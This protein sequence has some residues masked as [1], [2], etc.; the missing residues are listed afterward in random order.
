[1]A[2]VRVIT[3]PLL[4]GKRR[5]LVIAEDRIGHYPEFRAFFTDMFDLGRIGLGEPG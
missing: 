2:A 3:R 4:D 5:A 1:M